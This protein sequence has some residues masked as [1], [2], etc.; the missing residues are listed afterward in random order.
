MNSG[1]DLGGSIAIPF[2]RFN[3]RYSTA[4]GGYHTAELYIAAFEDTRSGIG[5]TYQFRTTGEVWIIGMA[6]NMSFISLADFVEGGNISRR[7]ERHDTRPLPM[8]ALGF[9]LVV[10]LLPYIVLANLIGPR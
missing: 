10:P 4:L 7:I 2:H 8:K 3:Y 9:G 5:T 1:I 6:F